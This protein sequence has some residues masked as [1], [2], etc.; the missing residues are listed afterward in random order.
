MRSKDCKGTLEGFG[1][2]FQQSNR[3]NVK[4]GILPRGETD[5]AGVETG[6]GTG[7]RGTVEVTHF[8]VF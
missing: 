3:Q 8:R 2:E 6:E 4:I 5:R 1:S 7:A